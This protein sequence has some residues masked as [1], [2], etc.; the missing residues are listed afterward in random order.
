M[1]QKPDPRL[2][3]AKTGAQNAQRMFEQAVWEVGFVLQ[4]LSGLSELAAEGGEH[5]QDVIQALVG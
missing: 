4:K 1:S 5:V 3:A 2:I